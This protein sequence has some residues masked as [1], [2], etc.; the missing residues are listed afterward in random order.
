MTGKWTKVIDRGWTAVMNEFRHIDRSQVAVGVFGGKE[1]DGTPLTLVAAA[2]EYGAPSR[3]IPARSF[4]RSSMDESREELV[5]LQKKIVRKMSDGKMAARVGLEIIGQWAQSKIQAKITSNI[6][7]PN[8][9]STA[10]KKFAK[11]RKLGLAAGRAGKTR[12]RGDQL[13]NSPDP[14]FSGI[15]TLI[16]TGQL[17]QSITYQVRLAKGS[18]LVP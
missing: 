15:R 10:R 2:N 9:P 6:P 16:D 1:S 13:E 18:E 7:P 14:N 11:T 12:V 5:E 8:A 3:N 17:R 4:I